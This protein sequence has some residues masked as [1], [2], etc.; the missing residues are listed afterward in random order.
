MSGKQAGSWN[1][2]L[3]TIWCNGKNVNQE[4]LR[5]GYAVRYRE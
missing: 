2:P 4:M 1:Q 5:L 3:V